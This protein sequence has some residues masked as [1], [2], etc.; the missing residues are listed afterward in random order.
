[1]EKKTP[2][3]TQAKHGDGFE[4]EFEV[5]LA[6]TKQV[7]G[8]PA[9]QS[10][11]H[12]LRSAGIEVD[13]SCESGTCGTCQTGYLIGTPDHQDFVLDADEQDRF[14]MP[15]VSRCKSPRIVLDI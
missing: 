8:I 12:A 14:L 11:L 13:S 15:C 3:T 1:M 9:G 2:P 10:I 7:I 6:S 5:E 4:F